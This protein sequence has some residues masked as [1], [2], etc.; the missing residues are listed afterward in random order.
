M[1]AK[2]LLNDKVKV[3]AFIEKIEIFTE[4]NNRQTFGDRYSYFI[5]KR[6]FK[7]LVIYDDLFDSGDNIM[8]S[9][10]NDIGE[11]STY[12]SDSF[13]KYFM[14]LETSILKQNE[15]KLSPF[16]GYPSPREIYNIAMDNR[17]AYGELRAI[18]FNHYKNHGERIPHQ[19]R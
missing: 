13:I 1:V 12:N 4:I 19:W 15:I 5:N 10:I 11:M 18:I 17:K 14:E 9:V 7:I 3:L 6:Y 2:E 16:A 8:F